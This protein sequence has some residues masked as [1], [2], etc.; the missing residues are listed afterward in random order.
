MTRQELRV[1]LQDHFCGC[2]DPEAA[3]A[4]LLALLRMHPM[5]E[6]QS[7]AALRALIPDEGA[8]YLLLYWMDRADLTEHGG[9]VNGAWLTEIGERVRDALVCEEADGFEALSESSCVHGFSIESDEGEHDC[10]SSGSPGDGQDK[11]NG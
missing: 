9:S 2:G 5:Y 10:M 4:T 6:P 1:F 3:S 7:Q 8:R 11:E